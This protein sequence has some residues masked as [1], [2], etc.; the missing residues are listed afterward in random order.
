M[1]LMLLLLEASL[2]S[3]K[4]FNALALKPAQVAKKYGK[5][6]ENMLPDEHGF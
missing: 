6:T 5:Y 3:A 1:L 2:G 4:D